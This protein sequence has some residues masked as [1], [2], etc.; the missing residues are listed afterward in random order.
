MTATV[1]AAADAG[2]CW[3]RTRFSPLISACAALVRQT[4]EVSDS[5]AV[6]N[7][8]TPAPPITFDSANPSD[9]VVR[10]MAGLG[11]FNPELGGHG[12]GHQ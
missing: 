2:R 8:W 3:L 7:R 6:R 12:K 4:C 11:G 1:A 9:H 10:A 5:G